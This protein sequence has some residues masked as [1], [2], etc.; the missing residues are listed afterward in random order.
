VSPDADSDAE[1]M[2]A[3]AEGDMAA[4]G[5]LVRRHEKKAFALAC[6]LLAQPDA[7]ED[8]TQEAFLHVHRAARRYRPE[9]RFTTWF[10]RIVVNLCL[11]AKRR[12][13]RAPARLAVYG[14]AAD[15]Q[16]DHDQ[17]EATERAE[18]VRQAVDHLPER[19]RTA[20]V[21]HRYMQLS[22]R[23]IAEV[24]GWSVS[25]VESCLVRAYAQLR[26]ELRDLVEN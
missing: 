8:V 26:Q 6:R 7:A 13:K 19:Q 17:L 20:V 14:L 15:A 4:L 3:V 21:L 12:I 11:D 23:D 9:A 18:R 25:A 22:H 2:R 16:T 10:Y 24:T 5:E 1:L